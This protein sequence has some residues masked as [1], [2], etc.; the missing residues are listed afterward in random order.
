MKAKDFVV[1]SIKSSQEMVSEGDLL[2]V[3]KIDGEPGTKI[4]FDEVLLTNIAGKVEVGKP[5]IKGIKV[6]AEIV[7]Q[8][9]ADKVHTRNY[10]AK[11]RYRKHT[12]DRKKL[13]KIK[14]LSI[15]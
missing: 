14:I 7:E 1:V 3:D 6:E 15:K 12:G 5:V 4:S 9:K 8:T 2:S 11:S 10:R 13:T